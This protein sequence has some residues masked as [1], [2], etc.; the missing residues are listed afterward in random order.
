MEQTVPFLS[1]QFC[2]T[3]CV[4]KCMQHLKLRTERHS[5]VSS[6]RKCLCSFRGVCN[7]FAKEFK[8]I[9]LQEQIIA[10]SFHLAE[11]SRPDGNALS[12]LQLNRGNGNLFLRDTV[13]VYTMHGYTLPY[14]QCVSI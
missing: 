6:M 12:Q 2:Y 1:A 7:F 13:G 5:L 10:R 3:V 11:L 9:L 14:K 4:L 8:K